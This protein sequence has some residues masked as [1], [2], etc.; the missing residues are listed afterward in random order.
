V[1]GRFL[2]DAIHRA[3]ETA[4]RARLR[5]EIRRGLD[6]GLSE[7]WDAEIIK[8][9]ARAGQRLKSIRVRDPK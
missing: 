9:K 5:D 7:I 6:S 8:R 2:D 4:R 3:I 1:R